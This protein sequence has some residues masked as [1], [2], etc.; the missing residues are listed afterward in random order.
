[1]EYCYI[2]DTYHH[3]DAEGL[4]YKDRKDKEE[5][6]RQHTCTALIAHIAIRAAE[7]EARMRA[8]RAKDARR[9]NAETIKREAAKKEMLGRLQ[10]QYAKATGND[11]EAVKEKKDEIK[12]ARDHGE[13]TEEEYKAQIAAIDAEAAASKVNKSDP[14]AALVKP[15]DMAK[16]TGSTGARPQPPAQPVWCA[17]D[18][19]MS[20]SCSTLISHLPSL[21]RVSNS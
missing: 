6:R 5:G 2:H 4:S 17:D 8:E 1:M 3:H 9:V 11:K 14:M 16:M 15:A 21:P 7:A 19:S 12:F 10:N 18:R 20:P 13:I